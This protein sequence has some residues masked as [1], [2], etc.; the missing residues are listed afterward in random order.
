MFSAIQLAAVDDA[1]SAPSFVSHALSEVITLRA[2]VEVAV[3]RMLAAT[4]RQLIRVPG[5][6]SRSRGIASTERPV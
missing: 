3:M 1:A 4:G 2:E 6:P 5:P